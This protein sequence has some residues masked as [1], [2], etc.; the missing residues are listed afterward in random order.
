MH[1]AVK[2]LG[3]GSCGVIHIPYQAVVNRLIDSTGHKGIAS[4]LGVLFNNQ[5]GVSVLSSLSSGTESGT[6]ASYYHYIPGIIHGSAR[7]NLYAIVNE[8]L[9]IGN[10]SLVSCIQNGLLKAET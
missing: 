6:T 4:Q 8:S 5:Y 1:P 2:S 10:A 9:T 7:L 3:A